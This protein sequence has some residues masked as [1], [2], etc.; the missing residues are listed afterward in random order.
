MFGYQGD[1]V[2]KPDS[3]PIGEEALE[4]IRELRNQV[5]FY[6]LCSVEGGF[7]SNLG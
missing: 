4:I 5:F 6:F 3:F 2:R 7:C 1:Q